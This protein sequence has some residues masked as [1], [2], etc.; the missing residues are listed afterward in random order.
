MAKLIK[1]DARDVL[2]KRVKS[3]P[4]HRRRK[5]IEFPKDKATVAGKTGKIRERDEGDPIAASWP[6]CF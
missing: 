2:P 1:F 5:V 4:R 6:G 3:A